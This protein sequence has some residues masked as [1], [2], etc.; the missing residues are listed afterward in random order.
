VA[1]SLQQ[2]SGTVQYMFMR[3]SCFVFCLRSTGA[4]VQVLIK[5]LVQDMIPFGAIFGL[6]LFSFTGA[7]YFALRGEEFTDGSNTSSNCSSFDDVAENC[8]T[9]F[10]TTE[11]SSLDIHSHLTM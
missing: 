2:S 5:I 8:V 10:T 6:F 4:Y 1:L 3:S 9:N 7:F 11:S